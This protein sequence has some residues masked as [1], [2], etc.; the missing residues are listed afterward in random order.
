MGH[1]SARA[2]NRWERQ[3]SKPKVFKD[4][5]PIPNGAKHGHPCPSCKSVM[6]LRRGHNGPFYACEH[7][8][9]CRTTAGAHS[10]GRPLGI[11]A[12]EATKKMRIKAHAAFDHL[13]QSGMRSR[14]GAYSWLKKK[15]GLTKDDC[16]IGRMDS[17]Q[18]ATVI[19]LVGKLFPSQLDKKP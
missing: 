2:Y 4:A 6:T 19:E 18:C 3:L 13:W 16:H 7:F 8:P 15:M 17:S 10:D 1:T 9:K 14:P 12:D 11:P 5:A